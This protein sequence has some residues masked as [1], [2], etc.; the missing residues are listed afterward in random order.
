MKTGSNGTLYYDGTCG[1]CRTNIRRSRKTLEGIGV[2]V[3]PFENGALEPEMKLRLPNGLV[4]GGAEAAFYLAR[5]IWWLAPLGYLE[6]VPLCKF[7]A[8]RIYEKIAA[9][10]HCIGGA[11]RI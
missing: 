1:F 5:R 8:E 7:L 4:H 9:N 3:E 10:R 2:A 11:C 6:R